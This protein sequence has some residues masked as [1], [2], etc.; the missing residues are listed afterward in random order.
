MIEIFATAVLTTV[1]TLIVTQYGSWKNKAEKQEERTR[2]GQYLSARVVTVLDPFIMQCAEVVSDDGVYDEEG[3][4]HT[5]ISAP[6][7]EYPQDVDW[8]AIDPELMYRVLMLPN[9]VAD[10]EQS[11]G[12]VGEHVASPP[13][14]EEYFE[15]RQFQYAKVGL[16]ALQL[17]SDLRCASHLPPKDYSAWDPKPRFEKAFVIENESRQKARDLGRKLVAAHEAKNAGA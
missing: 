4:R 5:S 7:I 10:A 2:S 9:Q 6:A 8:K 14:Y 15:E 16:I 17:A 3:Y 12:N 11:I 13:D 1:G